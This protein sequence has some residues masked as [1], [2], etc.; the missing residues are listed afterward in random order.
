[1]PGPEEGVRRIVTVEF[2]DGAQQDVVGGSEDELREALRRLQREQG[3]RTFVVVGDRSEAAPM[4]DAGLDAGVRDAGPADA[5]QVVDAARRVQRVYG[6]S[7]AYA[8]RAGAEGSGHYAR[9]P[10]SLEAAPLAPPP[11]KVR[12]T[13][14]NPVTGERVTF[15]GWSQ[16]NVEAQVNDFM[17]A[18]QREQRSLEMTGS[19]RLPGK[20]SDVPMSRYPSDEMLDASRIRPGAKR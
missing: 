9:P 2:K 17:S 8:S 11:E 19:H 1:M 3:S 14:E 15:E 10:W 4:R 5:G 13:V 6:A 16:G 12:K 18:R 7:G 20:A